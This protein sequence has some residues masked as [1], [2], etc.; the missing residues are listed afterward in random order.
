MK[1]AVYKAAEGRHF[2]LAMDHY[3]H[4]TSPIRRYPDMIVHRILDQYFSGKLSSPQV[5]NAWENCLPDWA[6]HCSMTERRADDAER[7]LPN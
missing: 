1:Q 4:F 5:Q 2:A 3:T 7:K 6:A